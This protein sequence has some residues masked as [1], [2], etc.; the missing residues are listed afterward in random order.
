MKRYITKAVLVLALAT[1]PVA[2]L[3]SQTT[4]PTGTFRTIT[5]TRTPSGD[6]ITTITTYTF[7]PDGSLSNVDT[8]TMVQ[9]QQQHTAS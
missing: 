3:V 1:A 4:T 7:N 2:E 5:T 6:T 8:Q 9:R